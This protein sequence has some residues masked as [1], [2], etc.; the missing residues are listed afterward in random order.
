MLIYVCVPITYY[1]FIIV[2]L[3]AESLLIIVYSLS[4][5]M[6]DRSLYS[7][8]GGGK[9]RKQIWLHFTNIPYIYYLFWSHFLITYF[10]EPNEWAQPTP[11]TL[12]DRR[13]QAHPPDVPLISRMPEDPA[14]IILVVWTTWGQETC[15]HLVHMAWHCNLR[16][17]TCTYSDGYRVQNHGGI[18]MQRR[19][20]M[21]SVRALVHNIF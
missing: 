18:S 17:E 9:I 5:L 3:K 21:L 19:C 15:L 8:T 1:L 13:C 4:H 6:T 2:T 14:L 11:P 12:Q 16:A 10:H 20:W 7:S